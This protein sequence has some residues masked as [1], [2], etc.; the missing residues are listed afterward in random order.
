MSKL[1]PITTTGNNNEGRVVID[2]TQVLDDAIRYDTD[3][4]EETM[5]T[6]AKERKRCKAAEHAWWE[7]QAWLEAKRVERER[8][9][10]KRAEREKAERMA[11][12]AEEQRV[13]EEEEK[14][15]AEEEREAEQ[16]RK[17]EA[18]KGDEA[19]AGGSEAGEVKK[20]VMDPSC[21]HCAWA[22]VVCEFLVDGNKK[23]VA[24]VCC[25]QSK[26]K[27]RWPG[28]RKDAEAGPKAVKGKKRKVNEE[29]AK[30][31]P[32]NQKWA[33]TSARLTEVLDL[34]EPEASGSGQRE[35]GAERYSGLENKLEQL[36]EAAG[37]IANN[38]AS[39]FELHETTVENS[40]HIA[41]T[42]ESILDESYGFGMA[43]SPSDSGSSELDSDELH[44]EAEWLKAHSK[45]EEEESEGEDE[46][47]AEAK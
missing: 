10:A 28:D 11:W 25:N 36:I 18:G 31:R 26:G 40:G 16:R 27:C 3:N 37:L 12:E 5:R 14:C 21:T 8:I 34:D 44:E 20:V 24:C 4:E 47:M 38:L 46:S 23:W 9:E 33:R 6:K 17:A 22:Q 41:N 39:L 1:R 15:K 19:R 30:A 35:A 32:S 45:D 43:V 7:E 2:W 13:C 29:N 42:L